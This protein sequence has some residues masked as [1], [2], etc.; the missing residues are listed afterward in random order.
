MIIVQ[1]SDTHILVPGDDDSVAAVRS[2]NF[3]RCVDDINGLEPQPD[4]VIH[5]GD[6]T[7]LGR[8]E[9]FAHAR[10]ILSALRAPWVVTPGNRDGREGLVRA[11]AGEAWF[12]ATPAFIHYAVEG[13]PVRLVCLDSVGENS[14]K[15]DFC[16]A[17]LNAL[18]AT[19]HESPDR[20]TALFLHH[21]LFDLIGVSDPFPYQRRSAVTELAVVLARHPQVMRIFCGHAHR[22]QTALFSGVLTSTVPSIAVDL[23]QGSYP[24]AMATRPVYQIHRFSSN[25]TFISETRCSEPVNSNPKFSP[26]PVAVGPL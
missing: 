10:E 7:H 8:D 17:R 21:P 2:E 14:R 3:R 15:G 18:D 25:G 20:P 19:L 13:F 4:V 23:R 5:T 1:I 11:F 22:P 6:M 9:E 12:Q 26:R 16:E 24:E